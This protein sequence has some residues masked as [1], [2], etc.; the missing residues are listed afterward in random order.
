MAGW[1]ISRHPEWEMMYEAGLTVREIADRCHQNRNTVDRHLKIREYYLPGLRA[2]HKT[3]FAARDPDSPST[4]WRR[5]LKEAQDFLD[6]HG[7]L[8]HHDG[9]ATEESLH[10][11][12]SFQR[13]AHH[14]GALST[15]K[16]VLL[17]SLPGW[18]ASSR[19]QRLDERWLSRLTQFKDYLTATDQLPRYKNYETEHEHTLGVWLHTQHQKRAEKTLQ[20]WR[21]EAL[22]ATHPDWRSRT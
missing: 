4:T 7:R 8:P 5:R 3:A 13:R 17:R 1:E 18:E 9:D 20:P 15:P 14:H 10:A 6:A 11:W 19:E 12:I 22:K 16:L 21:Y 2:R